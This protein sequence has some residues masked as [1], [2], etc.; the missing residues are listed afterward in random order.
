MFSRNTVLTF[1]IVDWIDLKIKSTMKRT[2]FGFA[3]Y[4][5]LDLDR[6]LFL[7]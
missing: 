5:L 4:H 2:V 1:K 3:V 6:K 7:N